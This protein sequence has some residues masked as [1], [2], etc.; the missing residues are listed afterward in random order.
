MNTGN[1]IIKTLVMATA[2]HLVLFAIFAGICLA[3]GDRIVS[4]TV[5]TSVVAQDK[6]GRDY[7]KIGIPEGKTLNG[8]KYTE[9]VLIFCFSNTVEKARTIKPGDK[10]SLVVNT[11]TRNGYTNNR[12]VAIASHTSAK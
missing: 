7:V 6:N 10:V 2:A 5:T 4:G 12:L 1:K 9:D 11:T 8:V 3:A